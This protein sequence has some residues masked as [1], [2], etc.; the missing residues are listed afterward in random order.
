MA[1]GPMQRRRD[2]MHT[3]R[4][5]HGQ[6][7]QA[8][9]GAPLPQ[10]ESQARALLQRLASNWGRRTRVKQP[11]LDGETLFDDSKDDFIPDLLPFQAHPVFQ[12]A[13]DDM[14]KQILSCG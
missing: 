7:S 4:L 3:E 5:A 1:A 6:T 10:A 13:P 11:E 8:Q 2:A 12:A 9:N 14:R